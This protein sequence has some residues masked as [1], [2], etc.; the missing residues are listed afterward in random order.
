VN[1]N[2]KEYDIVL[3]FAAPYLSGSAYD[4]YE[5][6]QLLKTKYDCALLLCTDIPKEDIIKTFTERY[7]VAPD[8]NVLFYPYW[9]GHKVI[10][11]KSNVLISTSTYSLAQLIIRPMLIPIK[12]VIMFHETVFNDHTIKMAFS[13]GVCKDKILMLRD[14][15]CFD[16]LEP[17]THR[18]YKKRLNFDIF[19][20]L[21]KR[22]V[23]NCCLINMATKHK[24]YPLNVVRDAMDS[25]GYDNYLI[26]TQVSNYDKFKR[27]IYNPSYPVALKRPRVDVVV[28][29]IEDYLYKF[30]KFIYFQ[31]T[32]G[33]D[34]SPRIIPE[35]EYYEK[36]ICF[37]NYDS[38]IEDGAKYRWIDCRDNFDDLYLKE[39][40][41]IFNIIEDWR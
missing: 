7:T 37:W 26:Y 6:Y 41:E 39:G 38:S 34:P 17:Y 15:R 14:D 28:A 4:A 24:E 22:P 32:R 20:P 40:D 9:N 18:T 5:Y 16:I 30:D 33:Q 13:S 12:K 35:C 2:F 29:P 8:E 11:V 3:F 23:D 31:S 27:L 21:D 19:R 1:T 25:F 36:K 10:K